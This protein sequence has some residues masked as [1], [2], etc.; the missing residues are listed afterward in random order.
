MSAILPPVSSRGE[1]CAPCVDLTSPC[2]APA[3]VNASAT[4]VVSV[5]RKGCS[6]V[7]ESFVQA[8]VTSPRVNLPSEIAFFDLGG[9][10]LSGC[11]VTSQ[12]VSGPVDFAFY[13]YE[14]FGIYLNN[15]ISIS[16]TPGIGS[17]VTTT[18]FTTEA[19][20]V[21]SGGASLSVPASVFGIE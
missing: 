11:G 1:V 10:N 15:T 4:V 2:R 5:Y 18:I 12:T 8:T 21:I 17:T 19:V 9:V 14:A 16:L 13:F 20:A 3:V 7:P 6:T